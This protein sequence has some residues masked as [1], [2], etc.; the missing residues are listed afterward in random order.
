MSASFRK[1]ATGGIPWDGAGRGFGKIADVVAG[2]E[3]ARRAGDYDAADAVAL[4]RVAQCFGHL[5]IH[6]ECQRVLFFRAVQPY[7]ADRSLFGHKD[8]LGHLVVSIVCI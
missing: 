3:S 7:D 4:I 2:G 1:A 5:L 8:V 6:G